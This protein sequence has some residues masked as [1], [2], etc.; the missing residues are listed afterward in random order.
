MRILGVCTGIGEKA[1]LR[2][3]SCFCLPL[4]PCLAC[5]IHATWGPP[6]IRALYI[7]SFAFNPIIYASDVVRKRSHEMCVIPG[8]A[9]SALHGS[10]K[11]SFPGLV[12]FVTAVAY[13]LCL[14]LPRAFSQPGKH[15]FGDPCTYATFHPFPVDIWAI[16]WSLILIF[17]NRMEQRV[18]NWLTEIFGNRLISRNADKRNRGGKKWPAP[19]TGFKPTRLLGSIQQSLYLSLNFSFLLPNCT[20]Y[21]DRQKSCSQVWRILLLPGL[22]C[23]ILATWEPLFW[24]P[25]YRGGG[26]ISSQIWVWL[27]LILTLHHV[28]VLRV[29]SHA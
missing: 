16:S 3:G 14:N 9:V 10:P 4:L 28:H 7:F 29:R 24:R 2:F 11:E 1:V 18:M 5:S 19:F 27:T 6:F 12:N 23:N 8:T 20:L 26:L 17:I 13:H 22:D 21:R 15:S 25:L